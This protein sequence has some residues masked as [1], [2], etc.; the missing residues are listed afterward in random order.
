MVIYFIVVFLLIQ[1][2]LLA[3]VVEAYMKVAKE[4]EDIQIEEEFV[5]DV[6][7]C[8]RRLL[9]SLK[10]GWPD[11]ITLGHVVDGWNCR[12]SVGFGAAPVNSWLNIALWCGT[13]RVWRR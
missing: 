8:S 10:Y 6:I 1:N 4:I 2:F 3:I 9:L 13:V 5:V 11:C 7:N 12:M